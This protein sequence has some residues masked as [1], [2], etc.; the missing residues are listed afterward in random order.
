[1]APQQRLDIFILSSCRT[2]PVRHALLRA[3]ATAVSAAAPAATTA[4]A[5]AEAWMKNI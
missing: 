5:L 4:A 2:D 3:A 1:M